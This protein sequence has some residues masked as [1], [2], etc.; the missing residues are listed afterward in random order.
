M[1]TY[2]RLYNEDGTY[3]WVQVS[4][5]NNGYNDAVYET[6][7]I[8]VLQLSR[9]E[10]PFYANYGIPAQ[11]AV[12]QQLFP[13]AYVTQ[14]QAQF[15]QFFAS[16]IVGRVAGLATPTYTVNVTTQQGYTP[17]MQGIPK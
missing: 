6:A 5:D 7:L 14:T 1:R 15:A 9:G 8:Q 17:S 4:T 13:D 10:S 2:G 12:L 16:L 3:T 11:Q